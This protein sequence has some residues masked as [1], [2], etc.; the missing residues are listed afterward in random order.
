MY[1]VQVCFLLN[2]HAAL[3]LLEGLKKRVLLLED[4]KVYDGTGSAI[5]MFIVLRHL[6]VS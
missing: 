6:R 2:V 1:A 4:G 5:L 3:C